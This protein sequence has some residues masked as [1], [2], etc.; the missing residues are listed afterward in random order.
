MK[1]ET[2]VQNYPFDVAQVPA[3]ALIGTSG[4]TRHIYIPGKRPTIVVLG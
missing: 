4:H 2:S 1:R 3:E